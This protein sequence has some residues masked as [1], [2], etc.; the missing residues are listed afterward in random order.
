VFLS[1]GAGMSLVVIVLTIALAVGRERVVRTIRPLAAHVGIVSGWLLILAGSRLR[2][3]PGIGRPPSDGSDR[4]RT[5]HRRLVVDP[6][7]QNRR[8]GTGGRD[9]RP[10]GELAWP[11]ASES[12]HDDFRHRR[13]SAGSGR[14]RSNYARNRPD[15][16]C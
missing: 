6:A 5:R 8:S 4:R 7:G 11:A 12:N 3:G 9:D 16:H 10:F 2:R 15:R 14:H 13:R 1:Y